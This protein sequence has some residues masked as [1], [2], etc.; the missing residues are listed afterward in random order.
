MHRDDRRRSHKQLVDTLVRALSLRTQVT[1]L[2]LPDRKV[3]R[4]GDNHSGSGSGARAHPPCTLRSS[5]PRRYPSARRCFVHQWYI[6]RSLLPCDQSWCVHTLYSTPQ[7]RWH[8][9][10]Y[11]HENQIA[12]PSR[13]GGAGTAHTLAESGD[14][15]DFFFGWAQGALPHAITL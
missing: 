2:T 7:A 3:G 1:V 6:L 8:K 9:V 5:F 10:L 15:R 13:K 11:F 14:E 4:S 12:Y